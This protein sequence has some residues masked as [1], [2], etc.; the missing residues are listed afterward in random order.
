MVD[1]SPPVRPRVASALHRAIVHWYA[2]E[3]RALPW[4]DPDCSAWGVLVSEV[5]LQQTRVSRVEPV[6]R[7]WLESWPTPAELAAASTADALRAWGRLGYPRRA[8]R[9]IECAR[10][11]VD[12]HGG[13]V[14]RG[15]DELTALPGV[16]DYTASAVLAFGFGERAVVLDTNVR[17]VLTRVLAGQALPTPHLTAAERARAAAALPVQ[18]DRAA[19]W[20]VG[21]MELG[22]LICTASSPDCAGCPLTRYCAWYQ[23]GLPADDGPRRR[24]QSWAGSDRQVR[25]LIMAALRDTTEPVSYLRLGTLLGVGVDQLDRCL[26]SLLADG[27]VQRATDTDG[28]LFATGAGGEQREAGDREFALGAYRLPS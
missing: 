24:V 10:M 9:L 28:S 2:E 17:R 3:A 19:A 25:G 26:A 22:A 8:L 4:R 1:Q 16:G 12:R 5:M 11:I 6:W 18:P 20:T 13:D 21:V 23:A 27:L 14:P 15:Y 7:S